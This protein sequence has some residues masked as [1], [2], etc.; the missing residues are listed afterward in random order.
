MI[1]HCSAKLKEFV[2]SSF[3]SKGVFSPSEDIWNAHLFLINRKK[4]IAFVHSRTRYGVVLF[5]LR[6]ADVPMLRSLFE[7][8]LVMQLYRDQI[9]GESQINAVRKYASSIHFLPTN[10]DKSAIGSLN[11]I[12]FRLT[13][14]VFEGP[15]DMNR[16]KNYAASYMNCSPSGTLKYRI[17][18]E[19]MRE[20]LDE[21][22][23]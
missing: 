10:N 3:L 1:I 22:T 2:G 17:P 13:Y 9:L 6:K 12:I 7:D 15:I 18:R 16:A 19:M 4:C 5:D 8:A 21:I 14:N 23:A 11:D 20:M